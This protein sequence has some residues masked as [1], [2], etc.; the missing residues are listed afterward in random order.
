MIRM[1]RRSVTRFFIPLL[2]VL[3]LLFCIFL[4]M[5]MST[6]ESQGTDS[7]SRE[8]VDDLAQRVTS[9]ERELQRRTV[10]LQRFEQ[11]GPELQELVRL[12]EEL[13]RLR[14]EKINT[15]QKRLVVRLLEIDGKTGELSYFDPANNDEPVIKITD[16]DAAQRLIARLKREA[17]DREE[18]YQFHLPRNSGFPTRADVEKYRRWFDA[19]AHSLKK[20]KQP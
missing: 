11:L 19:V 20:E 9:L 1:P 10:E 4:L 2:D 8:R 5:P 12:Q 7:A 18:Y 15:L 3:L 14:K 6:E 17:A 16:V 13:E